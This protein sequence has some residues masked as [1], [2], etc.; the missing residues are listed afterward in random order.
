VVVVAMTVVHIEFLDAIKQI[1]LAVTAL[2]TAVSFF[3]GFFTA[4]AYERWWDA[5]KLWGEF[6]NDSRSFGRLVATVFPSPESHPEVRRIQECLIRRHIAYLYS[7]KSRLRE[8]EQTESLSRLSE[9]DVVRVG[10]SGHLGN[11]LLE[12]QGQE[13]DSAERANY[14]DVIR[15]AQLNDMLSRFS[16][17]MG[18]VERIKYTV[19]PPYYASMIRFSIWA[20]IVVFS[21]SLSE[22]T[23]YWSMPYVFISGVVFQLVYRAGTLLLD[24]FEGKPDDIPIS[25][26]VRTI[27]INLLEQIGAEDI[28]SPIEPVDG[29]YLM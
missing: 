1:A 10:G 24:P 20:Y 15:M 25:D 28:P 6:V 7:V 8:E 5:R 4:Q 2:G 9:A 12:I 26:I 17:S 23:G 29:R 16:T 18:G 11:A 14:I 13:I 27:E 19:F 22:Q 21:I 3:I